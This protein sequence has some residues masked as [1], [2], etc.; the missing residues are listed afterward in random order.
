MTETTSIASKFSILN[1]IFYG[2]ETARVQV[3]LRPSVMLLFPSPIYG[4]FLT[5]MAMLLSL[6]IEAVIRLTKTFF[7][8]T[9]DSSDICVNLF[10][11]QLLM[12]LS[13]SSTFSSPSYFCSCIYLYITPFR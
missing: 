7:G 2:I 1:C 11:G 13:I 12:V 9:M 6:Q 8:V 10:I 3:L 4:L 5:T